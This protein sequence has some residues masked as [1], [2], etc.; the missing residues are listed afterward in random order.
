MLEFNMDGGESRL[1]Y[2]PRASRFT[3][4]KAADFIKGLTPITS[5]NPREI[6]LNLIRVQ[7]AIHKG[8][9]HDPA[10]FPF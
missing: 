10:N 3:I 2:P 7:Y 4:D 6:T 9:N 1:A 8:D 5:F